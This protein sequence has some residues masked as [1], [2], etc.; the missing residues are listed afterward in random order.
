MKTAE[1]K[2]KE[3]G[4]IILETRSI[5]YCI[6]FCGNHT[7]VKISQANHQAKATNKKILQALKKKVYDAKGGW[8]DKLSGI[9][10]ALQTTSHSGTAE[11]SFNL[12]LGSEAVIPAVLIRLFTMKTKP[13]KFGS[14]KTWDFLEETRDQVALRLAVRAQQ[15][16]NYYKTQVHN[17]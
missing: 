8:L 10:W 6:E 16:V 7:S 5:C 3:F 2:K 14:R 15:M 12:M 13:K 1:E 11:T 4:S 9:L 17:D